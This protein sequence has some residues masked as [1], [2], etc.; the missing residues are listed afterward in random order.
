MNKEAKAAIQK[1]VTRDLW[2]ER[3]RLLVIGSGSTIL[4]CFG[5]SEEQHSISLIK[6]LDLLREIR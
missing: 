1:T 3:K 4:A 5:R 2:D 6:S